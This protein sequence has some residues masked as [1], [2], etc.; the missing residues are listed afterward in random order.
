M[1]TA[2]VTDVGVTTANLVLFTY[3]SVD[4]RREGSGVRVNENMGVGAIVRIHVTCGVQLWKRSKSESSIGNNMDD[5]IN[6]KLTQVRHEAK[7]TSAGAYP[8]FT[9]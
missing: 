9:V 3:C 4:Q 5:D 8:N 6:S 7:L 2:V 1:W